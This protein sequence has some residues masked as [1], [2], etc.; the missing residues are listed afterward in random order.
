MKKYKHVLKKIQYAT[1]DME[2][3]DNETIGDITSKIE[4]MSDEELGFGDPEYHLEA[5]TKEEG[6]VSKIVWR[7]K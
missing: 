3:S 7:K 6:K 2:V 4:E 1:L 5:I